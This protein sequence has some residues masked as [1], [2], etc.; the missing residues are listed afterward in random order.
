MA[1]FSFLKKE[2]SNL[3]FSSF[4]LFW[5]KVCFFGVRER[6]E[7]SFIDC[8]LF[9]AVK[10]GDCEKVKQLLLNQK[11][12]V[13]QSPRHQVVRSLSPFFF[14]LIFFVLIFFVLIFFCDWSSSSLCVWSPS[15]SSLVMIL[16]LCVCVLSCDIDLKVLR[17]ERDYS[18][19]ESLWKRRLKDDYF[20]D[21]KWS[22]PRESCSGYFL[23]L[24]FF[25]VGCLSWGEKSLMTMFLGWIRSIYSRLWIWGSWNSSVSFWERLFS[26]SNFS[27]SSLFFFSLIIFFHIDCC[28][29]CVQLNS[30]FFIFIWL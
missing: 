8:Q 23:F 6:E 29:V 16:C 18:F 27:N 5:W 12:D 21:W 10:E 25:K 2:R 3:P 26:S 28:W 22:F 17:K 4:S 7:M 11:V 20:V 1:K 14:V 13:N 24:F 19:D 15:L 9:E 30:S